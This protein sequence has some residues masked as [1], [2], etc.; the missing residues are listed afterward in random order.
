MESPPL[1]TI[2]N[3]LIVLINSSFA[4][5]LCEFGTHWGGSGSEIDG[6]SFVMHCLVIVTNQSAGPIIRK[7]P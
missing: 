1:L 6:P 7:I 3:R 4:Q 2:L 5:V